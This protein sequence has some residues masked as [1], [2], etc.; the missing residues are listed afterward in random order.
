[1]SL[2]SADGSFSVEQFDNAVNTILTNSDPALRQTAE[3]AMDQFKRHENAWQVVDQILDSPSSV[4]AKFIALQ[5]LTDFISLQWKEINTEQ[6]LAIRQYIELHI[7]R[8]CANNTTFRSEKT[9]LNKLNLV[10]V[11]IVKKDWPHDWASFLPDIIGASHGNLIFCE[12]TMVLLRMLSEDILEARDEEQPAWKTRELT[13][14]LKSEMNGLYQLCTE[15][16][17][18]VADPVSLVEETLKAVRV[19]ALCTTE[20]SETMTALLDALTKKLIY[21]PSLII[22]NLALGCFS[23]L[24]GSRET[25]HHIPNSL[26][27]FEL[28]QQ[29]MQPLDQV[30]ISQYSNLEEHEQERLQIYTLT[31]TKFLAQHGS[32]PED[33]STSHIY[34]KAYF[35]LCKLSQADDEELWRICLEYWCLFIQRLKEAK[36]KAALMTLFGDHIAQLRSLTLERMVNPS[37]VLLFRVDEDGSIA[38]EF[39][40]QIDSLALYDTSRRLLQDITSLDTNAMTQTVSGAT[41]RALNGAMGHIPWQHLLRLS[42]SMDAMSPAMKETAAASF[43]QSLVPQLMDAFQIHDGNGAPLSRTTALIISSSLMRIGLHYQHYCTQHLDLL[44]GIVMQTLSLIRSPDEAV[45]DFACDTFMKLSHIYSNTLAQGD[46]VHDMLRSVP[47]L[48]AFCNTSSQMGDFYKGMG[49]L[50][51]GKPKESQIRHI[52][53]LMHIPNIVMKEVADTGDLL[54]PVVLKQ[55]IVVLKTNISVCE[56][57]D[58]AYGDQLETIYPIIIRI[59][60]QCGPGHGEYIDRY[61]ERIRELCVQLTCTY[62]RQ[63]SACSTVDD[64]IIAALIDT[65]C[66]QPP[67]KQDVTELL[68]RI[69]EKHLNA[70][71]IELAYRHLV[72][73]YE[74]ISSNFTDA[75]EKRPGLY[76]LVKAFYVSNFEDVLRLPQNGFEVIFSCML[77]GMQHPDHAISNLAIDASA[78]FLDKVQVMEDED[79]QSA[80]YETCFMRLLQVMLDGMTDRDRRTQFEL[81]SEVLSRLLDIVQQGEIYTKLNAHV[82]ASNAEFVEAYIRSQLEVKYPDMPRDQLDMV[83]RGMLEYSSDVD[84]FRQDWVDFMADF[85]SRDDF[86]KEI[87]E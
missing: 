80:V 55:F 15:I 25:I 70:G 68:A 21:S 77:W 20:N 73:V 9:I 83:A 69:L 59:Y 72:R 23:S 78:A 67:R 65:F 75:Y 35:D 28:V 26:S 47:D 3:V 37:E 49:Y 18:N 43:L 16:L 76:R 8:R 41:T 5:V 46:F 14:A 56:S 6:R 81:Q 64:Q 66:S 29:A 79:E 44:N 62:L 60:Q 63:K 31:L 87:Q 32:I 38:L 13:R 54:Q 27:V 48:I 2:L 53:E 86:A 22:R 39:A 82:Y 50:L 42:W 1:M 74:E 34:V 71:F 33:M 4:Q 7:V 52:R 57:L 45:R 12:N 30:T 17:D 40:R 11:Q 19:F 24:L 10:L 58:E 36:E 51:H 61:R 84:R 85:R